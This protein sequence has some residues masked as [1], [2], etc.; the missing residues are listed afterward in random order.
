MKRRSS[1][2]TDDSDEPPHPDPP[3]I[4]LQHHYQYQH[5]HPSPGRNFV[6]PPS[7]QSRAPKQS[8][9]VAAVAVASRPSSA[10]SRRSNNPNWK[11]EHGPNANGSPE[12]HSLTASSLPPPLSCF[13]LTAPS[14]YRNDQR[15]PSNHSHSQAPGAERQ[16]HQEDVASLRNA[17][18]DDDNGDGDNSSRDDTMATTSEKM[19]DVRFAGR[20]SR[21]RSPWSITIFALAV[22]VLGITLLCAILNSSWTRQIDAKGCR[23]SYMRPSYIR[24]RDFDT[25]HTRFA[26]KYSLYLYRE[27]GVDDERKLRGIPVLFIPG[28]A[29]S[30][31]QVRPIAAEAANYYHESLQ[32]DESAAAAGTRSLDFFTVD[33]NEDIT[34]FHGQTMLDQAEYLNEAIRY[35]LSLYMDPRMSARDQDLPDPTSVLVLG[36]SMGGIVARTMLIMPNYQ[37]NSIN[38]IITMS[39]PHSRPPVTFDGQIVK[40]Y[41]DINDYW[42][43]AYSQK[44]ANNNPLWHVT[45]VSIAGGGLDTVVPSDYA[46]VESI[47]PETHGFTV[48]TTGIPGVWASMDHQAILWCDQFRKVVARAMYDVVDVHRSSQT[49]PR[50]E[51]MRVFKKW[52]LTGMETI[53]EKSLPSEGPSTLLTLEDNSNAI[54]AQGERLVLR[55]LGREPKPRAHLLPV[56]PQGSPESKR[57]TLLSDTVLDKPGE[58]GKLEVLFCSVFPLQP[59][60]ATTLFSMNM[61]LSGDSTGSTRLACKNAAPDVIL[62]PPSTE[63][64]HEPFALDNEPVTRPFSYLQFDTEDI[65]DHQ[66]VAIVEKAVKPTRSFVVAEF[67]DYSQSHRRRNISLRRLLAFGMTL[68]LPSNRPMVA[69]INIPTLQSSLIA[70][71]LEIGNQVCGTTSELFSPMI[72]QHLAQP[73]ESKFFVNAR[74]ASISMHG[75]APFV[76]PPLKHKGHDEQGLSLQFWTDPTCESAIRVKLAVDVLGSLGKLYMRYRTVFAAFPLLVVTLVLRKQFRVYDT[77]GTFISFSESLDLCLRQSLPLMLLSLT[78]LSLSMTGSWSSGPGVFWHW[79]NT[80]STAADFHSN[81]LLTG[82]QDPFFWF[83]IPLIGVVCIGVCAVLHF[84][85]L[86]LTQLLGIVYSRLAL[87]SYGQARDERRRAQLPAFVAS[88]PRRRMVTTAVLLFLVSTFIPYQFAY[89]VA[90]LVQL[91]TTVRAL[92]IASELKS[93]PTFAFYHYAHSILLLMLWVLPINLPILAVWIRNL[94]VHWLTPFSS[95]HNVLSIMP[96]ILLVEN[97]TTG[98]MVPRVSGRMR[99]LTSVLLFGTAIYAAIYGVSYAYMLHYLVNFIAAWLVVVHSTNDNWPLVGFSSIF[100]N[101]HAEDRKRG[102]TP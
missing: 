84:V 12:N 45:L 41:D 83:L 16:T 21:P 50:A 40:I 47:I 35:I 96:F 18:D 73:Y 77:T 54:M 57:F 11:L 8:A 69:E 86:G 29:G 34:A 25:E 101:S 22:T 98:K 62:L 5:G 78:F 52:F 97:L 2:S 46:S 80:T 100:E 4:R 14:P 82:T 17:Q 42:R 27:Q 88:S 68:S 59:G 15:H 44:W 58:H 94:A 60:Q 26:T 13:S 64:R 75:V 43:H 23:M 89:L 39:A 38:T 53:A 48:F 102:K 56:P 87:R 66:F 93:G 51:R 9:V 33:F 30:Y 24:L 76:P 72:R 85:T 49:K 70:Y 71:S 81:D 61:D 1:G 92:R 55:Q 99:H 74:H 10:R 36:H 31:K 91:F 7:P 67:S 79:R 6:S 28:N 20:R 90:C 37:S 65:S 32:H 3:A 95:H 19:A 63:S